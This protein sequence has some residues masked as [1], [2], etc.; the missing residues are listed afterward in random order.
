MIRESEYAQ[1][2][3]RI[4]S[5]GV[6]QA[7]RC[8]ECRLADDCEVKYPYPK[9]CPAYEIFKEILEGEYSP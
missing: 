2:D 4:L 1:V 9:G 6:Y 5:D 7:R 8:T 3:L